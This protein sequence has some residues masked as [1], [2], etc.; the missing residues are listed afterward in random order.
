MTLA[1]PQIQASVLELVSTEA[2]TPELE[3][4]PVEALGLLKSNIKATTRFFGKAKK[5][6]PF[7]V[8]QHVFDGLY[9]GSAVPIGYM[10]NNKLVLSPPLGRNIKWKRGDT[11]VAI[12]RHARKYR[13]KTNKNTVGF[14]PR[15]PPSLGT[16]QSLQEASNA[17]Q[18]KLLGLLEQ[19]T[20]KGPARV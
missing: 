15:P 14:H 4:Y 5:G 19:Q 2:G 17:T 1:Y 6:V 9:G 11:V 7:G 8:L 12:V 16:I 20:G 18:A 10:H 3:F 13:S